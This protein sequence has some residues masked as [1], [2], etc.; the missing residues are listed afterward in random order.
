MCRPNVCSLNLE[1]LGFVYLMSAPPVGSIRMA[2]PIETTGG[3]QLSVSAAF[4]FHYKFVLTI[5]KFQENR[6]IRPHI[7]LGHGLGPHD[8]HVAPVSDTEHPAFLPH[9]SVRGMV[10]GLKGNAHLGHVTADETILR[11]PEA[12]WSH[13]NIG[14]NNVRAIN[15]GLSPMQFQS[16]YPR[17]DLYI[18]S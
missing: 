1:F 14:V 7:V 4:Q 15:H 3:V 12:A 13:A 5:Q 2:A 6:R 17:F 18:S 9:M 16:L 11:P 10:R 8:I